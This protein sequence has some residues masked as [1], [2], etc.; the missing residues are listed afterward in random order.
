M[1]DEIDKGECAECGKSW[2]FCTCSS[3]FINWDKEETD[4]QIV[5]FQED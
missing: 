3:E 2:Y 4:N 5:D 1:E